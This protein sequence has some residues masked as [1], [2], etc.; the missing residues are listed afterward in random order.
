MPDARRVTLAAK[1]SILLPRR[2]A[3]PPLILDAVDERTHRPGAHAVIWECHERDLLASHPS[4]VV[5]RWQDYG[6]S[7][8]ERGGQAIRLGG[9][10][11]ASFNCRLA[12]A[13]PVPRLPKADK[14]ERL[15]AVDFIKPGELRLAL[16]FPLEIAIG[17]RQ[18][19]RAHRS[20]RSAT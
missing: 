10:D 8:V 2:D 1:D 16:R 11:R 4:V 20:I 6:H 9:D 3:L 19:G 13:I 14:S 5:V 15:A 18:P 7:V 12:F 17:H